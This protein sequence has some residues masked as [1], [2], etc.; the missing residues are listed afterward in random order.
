MLTIKEFVSSSLI[1][2]AEG[3]EDAQKRGPAGLV[4][5]PQ[6]G[7]RDN[8]EISFDLAVTVAE[9]K[10]DTSSEKKGIA[11]V[12]SSLFG[13]GAEANA[14]SSKGTSAENS[15]VSRIQFTIKAHL[16][17]TALPEGPKPPPAGGM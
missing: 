3:L 17:D 4:I 6:R 11:V 13:L 16:P 12:F 10:H 1:Q 14:S 2:I 8:V 5:L 7:L 9:D 15:T